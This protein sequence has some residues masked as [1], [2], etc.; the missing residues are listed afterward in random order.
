MQ[1]KSCFLSFLFGFSFLFIHAQ[2]AD[3]DL[4]VRVSATVSKADNFINLSWA[5]EDATEYN[6]FRKELESSSWGTPKTTLGGDVNEYVD[7]DV[8]VGQMYEYMVLKSRTGGNGYGYIYSGIEIPPVHDRGGLLFLIDDRFI[9][10]LEKEIEL[11]KRLISTDGWNVVELAISMDSSVNFVKQ[12]IVAWHN[13]NPSIN[14]TILLFGHI[15]VPYSGNINPDGHGNHVGAWSADVYYADVDGN[16]TDQ[17]VNNTSGAS[18]RTHNIPGDGK[19]DNST[20][21]SDLE[22]QIGR[23]DFYN[24]P[25]FEETEAELLKKYI[26]K[27]IAFRT[28]EF[29]PQ[30]RALI[31]NNFGGF[32]EGFGQNGLRNFPTMFGDENTS[33]MDYDNL[34]TDS[35]LWSYGCGG[36]NYQ[37]ASGITNTTRLTTDSLQTVF[38]MLFGS[39]FGD[40]DS[41]N[42]FL[43][44]ALAS[45]T[46]LTNAWAGRPNW[47]FHPMAM[48]LPI[49]YCARISQNNSF[50]YNP[51]FGSRFVHTGLMGD[52]SLRM[53]IVGM[54]SNLLIQEDEA[55]AEL[56]WT[57]AEEDVLG[58]YIYRKDDS[59]STF[60]LLNEQA[61]IDTNFVDPC[62]TAGNEYEYIVR[63]SIL[64]TSPSGSYI[65]LS[66]GIQENIL[67]ETDI[68]V[69]SEFDFE[70]DL[71]TYSFIN[72][73]QNADDYLWDFGDGNTS[74]EENPIHIYDESGEFT[75]TLTAS[76]EC[77]SDSYTQTVLFTSTKDIQFYNSILLY[78]NPASSNLFIENNSDTGINYK[79]SNTL[80]N[81]MLKGVLK[82]G[83]NQL[84]ISNLTAGHYTVKVFDG[85]S[86]KAIRFLITR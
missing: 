67:I 81:T 42:N 73:S 11:F 12:E 59:N 55:K 36:G 62:L 20:I 35:Y 49:G 10:S 74:T 82:S 47:T 70:V 63:A 7:T 23:V 5:Q 72:L 52:P 56:S 86:D 13:L 71:N 57:A 3:F 9:Q 84:D 68:I 2:Q 61:I 34:L 27:N 40:W 77:G 37:G 24:L 80:G 26:N 85:K 41:Q 1:K 4:T 76:N 50:T 69:N 75:I 38:T 46:V 51:G 54:P 21:P 64:E 66:H 48:G 14:K 22:L 53:H 25:L 19:F 33:Y 79:L 16:W 15:P 43:R 44:S 32:A 17:S 30:R 6:I 8:V 60:T 39:Y 83:L 65:N 29:V 18:S 58:Y 28:K 78:P 45:G 31:E